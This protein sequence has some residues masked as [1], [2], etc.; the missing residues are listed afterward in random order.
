MLTILSNSAIKVSVISETFVIFSY[1]FWLKIFI[2]ESCRNEL[3]RIL[4]LGHAI[5]FIFINSF[6]LWLQWG[7]DIWIS[8]EL[9]E[10]IFHESLLIEAKWH[11]GK[12]QLKL[13]SQLNDNFLNIPSFIAKTL[14]M[15]HSLDETERRL[16][17]SPFLRRFHE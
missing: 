6:V 16:K 5:I 2:M 9:G 8:I 13:Y 17:F 4:N 14:K 10:K 15:T 7:A 3:S 11:S 12:V 1:I